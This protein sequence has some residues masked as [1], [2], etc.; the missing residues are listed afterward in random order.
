M[1]T[2]TCINVL[3]LSCALLT[4]TAHAQ[5][6][7]SRPMRVVVPLAAGGGMDSV[8]RNLAVSFT[9]A[10]GQS[11]I[12]DNRP[13]AGSL[14]AMEIVSDAA[15][16]GHTLMMVSA[17]TVIYPLLYK[18]RLDPVRDFA[19]VSQVTAQGY[20]LVVHPSLPVKSVLEFISHAKANPDKLTYSS[21]GIGSPIHMTTE[22]MQIATGTRLVHVPYKGMGAAYADLVGGR[23]NFSFA[24][25]ISAQA[26]IRNNRLRALAV[27]TGKRA[28]AMPDTP[29]M[30]EAGVPGVVVVNW[31]GL[32][33]P[34]ATPKAVID[35]IA[36]E[37]TR[38]VQAPAMMKHLIADGSEGVGS[39]RAQFT[40]HIRAESEQWRRVIKQGGIKAQ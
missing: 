4:A 39:T 10:L 5:T 25:I 30:A 1:N 17:T 32:I 31:Y 13:G 35:R 2:K 14:L 22:L 11:V 40:A 38:A 7:P 9:E 27:S 16:D 18:S 36:A 20:V 24:T 29:T 33:A 37:T 8:T 34:K 21:S 23:I 26:H 3:A 19:P 28:P 12:V 6:F 15:A